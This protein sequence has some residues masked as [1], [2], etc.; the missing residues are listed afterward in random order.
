[1]AGRVPVLGQEHMGKPR[2]DPADDRHD[3][4]AARYGQRA[5]GAEVVLEI[6]DR[7]HVGRSG[8]DHAPILWSTSSARR[9]S[10]G[11]MRT[12]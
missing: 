7:Q 3:V 10:A 1:M 5:P 8:R 9:T 12:G 4:G 11:A 6:D 2:R